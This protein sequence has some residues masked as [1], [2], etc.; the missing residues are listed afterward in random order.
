M[1]LKETL[2]IPQVTSSDNFDSKYG[3]QLFKEKFGENISIE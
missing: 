2:D 1:V 3:I